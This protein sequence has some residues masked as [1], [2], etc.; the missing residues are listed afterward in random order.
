[1]NLE[2]RKRI[3]QNITSLSVLTVFNYTL[4]L[5]L[6]PYLINVLSAELY[7]H[8][9][10]ARTLMVYFTLL[11]DYGFILS[12]TRDVAININ[13]REKL[14]QIFS[15]VMTIKLVLFFV[16]AIIFLLLMSFVGKFNAYKEIYYIS[17]IAVLGQALFPVWY[18]QGIEDMK[19]IT[20]I[21]I[22]CK[23]FFTILTFIFVQHERNYLY[24][25][26][27]YSLG[28]LSSGIWAL[29]ISKINYN[30]TIVGQPFIR[31]QRTFI[32]AS[33]FF[34]SRLSSVGY[35]NTNIFF[36]G[37][38]LLPQFVTYYFLADKVITAILSIF[39][40]IQQSIYPYL[41]RK[42]SNKIFISSTITIVGTSLITFIFLKIFDE[43]I[44]YFLLNAHVYS[45]INVL[46][47]LVYL[48]PISVIYVM[49]GA[50]LLLAKGFVKEFNNSIIYGFIGHLVLLC[51]VYFYIHKGK[52][53]T[54]DSVLEL[55]AYILILSKSVVL[56]FRL[57]Y[58]YKN[59][60]LKDL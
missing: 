42:F 39:H 53:T 27:F 9:I 32:E 35:N 21:N 11:V 13:N 38:I 26:L 8:V 5:L 23:T 19:Q 44:S 22:S 47:I 29:Y 58:V 20:I 6:I 12:A 10:L 3:F 28:F 17:F 16:S 60:I 46:N 25:P 37:I 51:L 15:S 41:S 49:L 59:K 2:D 4:P 57:F 43:Q 33:P 18:F 52:A 1:M 14:L 34:L 7:G 50:P 24:V 45:F 56:F 55:F 30:M 54:E 48:I 40:P 31:I 36:V